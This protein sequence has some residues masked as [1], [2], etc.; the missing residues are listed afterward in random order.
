VWMITLLHIMS[1]T[2]S[3]IGRGGGG[4]RAHFKKICFNL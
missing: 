1:F 4:A 2:L 3:F